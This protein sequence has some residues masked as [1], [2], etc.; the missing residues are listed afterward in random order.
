MTIFS[1]HACAPK[2]AALVATLLL[3][4]TP[5]QAFETEA[6][7]KLTANFGGEAI[8]QPTVHIQ[9]GKEKSNTA[10]LFV[11]KVGFSNLS[12][13]GYSADNKRLGI[14]VS[15]MSLQPGP[16]TA[17]IEQTVTYAS[18][19]S[20]AFW[21]SD[22]APKPAKITFTTFETKGNEGRAIGKF[23]AL[24][25][26]VKTPTAEPDTKNCRPIE[27]SFDTKFFV[28]KQSAS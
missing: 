25:C 23:E 22:G 19:G 27:G 11:Q 13:S 24:V 10:F 6:I 26:Y 7:G 17:Q 3:V 15:Y 20:T 1:S 12:L 5:A 9:S 14:D 16:K 21:T 18:G 8:T 2:L 4:V 28:E